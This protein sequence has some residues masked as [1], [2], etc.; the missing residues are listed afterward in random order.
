MTTARL[1]SRLA[2]LA[3]MAI[4]LAALPR[5]GTAA[6]ATPRAII[7]RASVVPLFDVG[8]RFKPHQTFKLRFRA[9]DLNS[10][11]AVAPSDI[12]FSL[13]H[14]TEK[15][16]VDLPARRVKDGVFEVGFTP[17][18]PGQYFV[19]ASVLGVPASSIPPVRLGVVGMADGIVELPQEA[20]AEMQRKAKK[21][22]RRR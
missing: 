11:A 18:G 2:S 10:G 22:A 5:P 1:A 19:A 12:S 14:A 6:A 20:D 15:T 13:R 17:E 7:P 16:A 8:K 21:M 3:T 4:A 9:R